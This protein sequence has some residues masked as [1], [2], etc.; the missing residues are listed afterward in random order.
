MFGV[1]NHRTPTDSQRI[2]LNDTLILFEIGTDRVRTKRISSPLL[3][4]ERYD[5]DDATG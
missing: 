2:S 1:D 3:W 5:D 4:E